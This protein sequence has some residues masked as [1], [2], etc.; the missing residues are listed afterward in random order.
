MQIM[1][2]ACGPRRRGDV[3]S[4]CAPPPL[5]IAADAGVAAL[6]NVQHPFATYAEGGAV[7]NEEQVIGD[8]FKPY[9]WGEGETEI[10]ARHK[11]LWRQLLPPE[12]T[13]FPIRSLEPPTGYGSERRRLQ[14]RGPIRYEPSDEEPGIYEEGG[15]VGW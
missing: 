4:P 5:A 2:V 3:D 8:D 7:D 15:A 12:G 6:Q 13:R 10:D 14:F 9:P 1:Q 11:F